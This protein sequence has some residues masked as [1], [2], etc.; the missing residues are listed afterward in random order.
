MHSHV[1]TAIDYAIHGEVRALIFKYHEHSVVEKLLRDSD[2]LDLR[3]IELV[4]SNRS[5]PILGLILSLSNH[6]SESHLIVLCGRE[7]F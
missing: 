7:A 1:T 6:D 4:Q 5:L 2:H 3:L